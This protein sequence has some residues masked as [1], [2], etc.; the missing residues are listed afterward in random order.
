MFFDSVLAFEHQQQR[1]RVPMDLHRIEHNHN[2]NNNNNNNNDDADGN[3]GNHNDGA[4]ARHGGAMARN[5]LS[6]VKTVA[7]R[8]PISVRGA[9]VRLA[10][11]RGGVVFRLDAVCGG[12]VQLLLGVTDGAAP[13]FASA[14]FAF[15]PGFDRL[16]Q[17]PLPAKF[18]WRARFEQ[19]AQVAPHTASPAP[20]DHS[21]A[22]PPPCWPLVLLVK[23]ARSDPRHHVL[24]QST[25]AVALRCANGSLELKATEQRVQWRNRWFVLNE[26]FGT[27]AVVPLVADAK[28]VDD[29]VGAISR[30]PD[31][32][33]SSSGPRTAT[34]VKKSD[35]AADVKNNN[36]DDD[37]DDDDDDGDDDDNDTSTTTDDAA[38]STTSDESASGDGTECV[39]CLSAPRCVAVMPCRHLSLCTECADE[40]RQR[41]NRCPICRGVALALLQVELR[42]R[43]LSEAIATDESPYM[44]DTQ[45]FSSDNDES[46]LMLLVR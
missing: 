6:T 12:G 36:N 21:L 2:N 40:V 27:A 14:E 44:S 24:V 9:S 10:A 13:E 4:P 22:A 19:L 30:S 33:D 37:D 5:R 15:E 45:S 1:A 8:C 16:V 43:A 18:D 32:N 3:H 20:D 31:D 23:A 46:P 34:N 39:V 17:I 25:H 42:G 35:A 7:L 38:K 41:T 28:D 11:D 26:L 29:V